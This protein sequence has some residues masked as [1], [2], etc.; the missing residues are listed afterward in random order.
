M[1]ESTPIAW[2]DRGMEG[3]VEMSNTGF[4]VFDATARAS[5]TWIDQVCQ[6]LGGQ[7]QRQ[8]GYQ[9]L[10]GVLHTLRD[11]STVEEAADLGAQL[12][13]LLRGVYY[14]GWKPKDVPTRLDGA[15]EFMRTVE[16]NMGLTATNMQTEDAIRAVSSVLKEHLTTGQ[17]DAISGLLP[18]AIGVMWSE[19]VP[20]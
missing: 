12:P 2:D 6:A 20:A 14:E 16:Q 3:D 5:L 10:R 4:E 15:D 9:A 17:L 8:D 18:E 7:T 11:C 13:F 1:A 19:A